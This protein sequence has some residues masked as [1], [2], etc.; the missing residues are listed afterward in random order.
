MGRSTVAFLL[1]IV[2]V[3]PVEVSGTFVFAWATVIL[4]SVNKFSHIRWRIFVELLVVTKDE[5][6]DIDGAEN[7]KLVSLLEKTTLSLQKGDRAIPVI[8]DRFDLNLSSSHV[9]RL[10]FSSWRN[11]S[12]FHAGKLNGRGQKDDEITVRDAKQWSKVGIGTGR[13]DRRKRKESTTRSSETSRT[14]GKC[15]SRERG[16][17]PNRK[18]EQRM[19]KRRA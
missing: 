7:G 6:G 3:A 8:F 11:V 9:E 5:D 15:P 19:V 13:A 12:R 10:C 16:C 1:I 2:I 4:I 14:I 17:G 18:R